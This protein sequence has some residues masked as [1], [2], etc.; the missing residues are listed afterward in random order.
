MIVLKHLVAAALL[1]LVVLC[2]C[3]PSHNGLLISPGGMRKNPPR[4]PSTLEA[5]IV[6]KPV[7]PLKDRLQALCEI[8]IEFEFLLLGANFKS[9]RT[10][11]AP[12]IANFHVVR[13]TMLFDH[14]S[15]DGQN[16]A[17]DPR[18]FFEARDR[19]HRLADA[20]AQRLPIGDLE[21]P[22]SK[23]Q[24]KAFSLRRYSRCSA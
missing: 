8:E 9:R 23:P 10:S 17:R 4:A 12:P 22:P 13:R 7:H 15:I 21:A 3:P 14:P 19:Q 5:F 2:Y 20:A 1:S 24:P 6:D 11:V 18:G 16:D